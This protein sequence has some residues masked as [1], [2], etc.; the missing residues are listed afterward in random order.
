MRSGLLR[1]RVT[2]QEYTK[3]DNSL[4]EP[5]KT[6][7]NISGTPTVWA[8]ITP[9]S[10]SEFFTARQTATETTHRVVMRYMDG[11]DTKMR[12]KFGSRYF[13][14]LSILNKDERDAELEIMCREDT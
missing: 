11:L 3:A 14:I 10:G 2:I 7:A 12:L 1:H 4:G 5:I 8:S 13:Y 6:W 9:M